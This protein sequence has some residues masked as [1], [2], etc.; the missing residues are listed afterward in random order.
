MGCCGRAAPMRNC[1]GGPGST[2]GSLNFN[3]RPP[4]LLVRPSTEE[5]DAAETPLAGRPGCQYFER[6]EVGKFCGRFRLVSALAVGIASL[7]AG[8]DLRYFA[9]AAYEEGQLLWNRRPIAEVLQQ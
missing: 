6:M 3:M 9:H 5:K 2:A 7:L 8:C 4:K 1:C